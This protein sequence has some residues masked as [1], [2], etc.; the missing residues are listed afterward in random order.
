MRLVVQGMILQ[1][2][3]F[4]TLEK[5]LGLKDKCLFQMQ[6]KVMDG[7]YL[8]EPF[9]AAMNQPIMWQLENELSCKDRFWWPAQWDPAHWLDKV[10]AKFKETSFVARLVKR[11]ALFHQLFSHGKM[12]SVARATA[13]DLS[14]PFRVTK[15]PTPTNVL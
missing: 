7:Q 6:G 4:V 12:H 1:R 8:N 3:Y 5:H 9:I 11:T 15:T 14:L 13:K 10:F 2:L